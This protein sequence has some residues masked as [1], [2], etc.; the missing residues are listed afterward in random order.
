MDSVRDGGRGLKSRTIVPIQIGHFL[1]REI[2][3]N[4]DLIEGGILPKKSIMVIGGNSKIGKSVFV[5]NMGLCLS[6]GHPMLLQFNIPNPTKVLYIQAEISEISMQRRLSRMM[7]A[8]HINLDS[9]HDRFVLINDKGIKLDRQQDL[10]MIGEIVS[11][12]QSEVVIIDPLYKFHS[13]NENRP[14]DMT[15]FFDRLDTLIAEHACSI[16][17]VHHFGKP[18]LE[19]REGGLQLR[20]ATTIFDYGDSYISLN[21]KSSNEPRSHVKAT[22]EL[23]NDEDPAAM[24]L[25][26]NPDSLWYE[27]LGDES[28]SKVTIH[29][30]VDELN[31]IGGKAFRKDLVQRLKVRTGASIRLINDVLVKSETLKKIR[32]RELSKPGK[33]KLIFLPGHEGGQFSEK[34]I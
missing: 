28:A 10:E 23:R 27:V 9:I 26:R 16:I 17:M 21:R 11:H 13:G 34:D 22:F 3:Q 19:K 12:Y 1:A 33:P 20:G 14:E 25:Y 30:V 29:D 4:D 24:F 6:A 31:T 18:T 15:K 7:N 5:C 2:P 32:S 8:G